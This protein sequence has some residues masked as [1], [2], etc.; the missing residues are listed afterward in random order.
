MEL[1]KTIGR[2]Y[3][4]GLV[5]CSGGGQTKIGKFGVPGITYMKDSLFPIPPLF[6][7]LQEARRL[8]WKEMYSSYNMGHRLEAVV[9]DRS[10]AEGCIEIAKLMDIDARIIGEV[11]ENKE[12]PSG[13]T[14]VIKNGMDIFEYNIS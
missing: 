4:L 14:V 6:R 7:F 3:L 11:V 12:N 2:E 9:R 10:T 1:F 13:R 8:P 5:H